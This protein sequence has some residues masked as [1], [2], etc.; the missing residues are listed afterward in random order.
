MA[1]FV[2]VALPGVAVDADL[3]DWLDFA[4]AYVE[5]LPPKKAKPARR[6]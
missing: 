6:R 4:L 3:E 5:K 2:L 1:G